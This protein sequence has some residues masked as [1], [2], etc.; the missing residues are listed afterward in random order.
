MPNIERNRRL[1]SISFINSLETRI[2]LEYPCLKVDIL[3]WHCYSGK[4]RYDKSESVLFCS[5][6]K[7]SYNARYAKQAA[8]CAQTEREKIETNNS[9]RKG[10]RIEISA[11]EAKE[12]ESTKCVKPGK[13]RRNQSVAYDCVYVIVAKAELV[14]RPFACLV[15]IYCVL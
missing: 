4:I 9:R 13:N 12:I 2:F 15:H 3:R 11:C 14:A 10:N 5:V 6:H 7:Y 8:S 1:R